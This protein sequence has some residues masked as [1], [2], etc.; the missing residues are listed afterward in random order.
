M[1]HEV[2]VEQNLLTLLESDL[3][4]K[5]DALIQLLKV[6]TV[7]TRMEHTGMIKENPVMRLIFNLFM[8]KKTIREFNQTFSNLKEICEKLHREKKSHPNRI[9]LNMPT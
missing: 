8:R 5:F 3:V 9:I 6:S 2:K 1:N 4:N 7:I